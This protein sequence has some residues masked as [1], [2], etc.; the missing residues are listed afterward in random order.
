MKHFFEYFRF[1]L[2]P[3]IYHLL[4]M[5]TLPIAVLLMIGNEIFI[6]ILVLIVGV[7]LFWSL[8]NKSIYRKEDKTY[9]KI[10]K[11]NKKIIDE[12]T[13]FLNEHPIQILVYPYVSET[14]DYLDES[15]KF[16][17]SEATESWIRLFFD[18]EYNF[19]VW[20]F[21]PD[22]VEFMNQAGAI[23][24]PFNDIAMMWG[25]HISEQYKNTGQLN[26]QTLPNSVITGPYFLVVGP[27][28]KYYI[29]GSQEEE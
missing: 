17:A 21:S 29:A 25:N 20:Q 5:L 23:L 3:G 10:Q 22:L 4:Y 13:K 15:G 1:G 6:G 16:I 19:K 28:L 8:R 12:E 11:S 18:A 24:I 9:K 7:P 27:D 14:S 2:L 26:L